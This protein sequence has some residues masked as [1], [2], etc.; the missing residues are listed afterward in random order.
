MANQEVQVDTIVGIV[1]PNAASVAAKVT[2]SHPKSGGWSMAL[3]TVFVKGGNDPEEVNLGK[4]S[5]VAGKMLEVSVVMKNIS[6]ATTKMSLQVD[7]LG[8]SGTIAGDIAPGHSAHYSLF[9][10]F[11]VLP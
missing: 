1:D 9:V 5:D 3:A 7:V 8:K 2:L 6:A 4:G 10:A 11:V